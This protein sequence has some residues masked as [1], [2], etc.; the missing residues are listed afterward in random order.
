MKKYLI[1]LTLLA[2]ACGIQ[3]EPRY[4]TTTDIAPN[5]PPAGTYEITLHN[6]TNCLVGAY[7]ST[8][9]IPS[10]AKSIPGL[11]LYS[12][13]FSAPDYKIQNYYSTIPVGTAG[14]VVVGNGWAKASPNFPYD[15]IFLRWMFYPT[16]SDSDTWVDGQITTHVGIIAGGGPQG[17]LRGYDGQYVVSYYNVPTDTICSIEKP[18]LTV[19]KTNPCQS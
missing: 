4:I 15:T 6:A 10:T 12:Y 1:S 13:Y 16:S 9:P 3:A 17:A 2:L 14:E 5:M 11:S 19:L 7:S 18:C 8:S